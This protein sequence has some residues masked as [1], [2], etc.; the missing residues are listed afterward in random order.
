MSCCA[1]PA[2]LT[3]RILTRAQSLPQPQLSAPSARDPVISSP[4]TFTATPNVVISDPTPLAIMKGFCP[5]QIRPHANTLK[6]L[7][8]YPIA[9]RVT[10]HRNISIFKWIDV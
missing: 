2:P 9:N 3:C 6:Y 4:I 10:I 7:H 8:F 1:A 5:P